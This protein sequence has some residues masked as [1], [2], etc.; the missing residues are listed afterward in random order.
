MTGCLGSSDWIIS[1]C[2]FCRNL[3]SNLLTT[4]PGNSFEFL[5]ALQQLR[6]DL[7]N[8]TCRWGNW[9]RKHHHA[10]KKTKYLQWFLLAVISCGWRNIYGNILNSE[11]AQSASSQHSECHSVQMEEEYFAQPQRAPR[12]LSSLNISLI[13]QIN[14]KCFVNYICSYFAGKQ[15]N[16]LTKLSK[17]PAGYFSKWLNFIIP[18]WSGKSISTLLPYQFRC[19]GERKYLSCFFGVFIIFLRLK[20]NISAWI[21]QQLTRYF[22]FCCVGMQIITTLQSRIYNPGFISQTFKLFHFW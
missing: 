2:K 14:Y 10:K 6:L 17:H 16:F 9:N 11:W 21:L 3:N 5:P 22:E 15:N 12:L 7:N 19:N 18:R 4:L 13:W 8:F 1:S 20:L